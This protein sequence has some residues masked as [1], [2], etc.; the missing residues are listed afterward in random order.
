M[1]ISEA[2]ISSYICHLILNGSCISNFTWS[3]PVHFHPKYHILGVGCDQ[4][5]FTLLLPFTN[6]FLILYTSKY[7][8]YITLHTMKKVNSDHVILQARAL[9][10]TKTIYFKRLS[11]PIYLSCFK[12]HCIWIPKSPLQREWVL[13]RLC[14]LER[15][16]YSCWRDC[17][18]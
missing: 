13:T 1:C 2:S 9:F 6:Y 15:R 12:L 16:K 3:T 8:P 7:Y 5:L 10:H 14:I 18:V 17:P 4:A 11:I